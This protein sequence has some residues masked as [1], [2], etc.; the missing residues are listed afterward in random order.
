[1]TIHELTPRG[2]RQR[3]A[4]CATVVALVLAALLAARP[5]QAE[6]LRQR[7][8]S[9]T[10]IADTSFARSGGILL[11]RFLSSVRLGALHAVFEGRKAPAYWSRGAG[12][13]ALVPIPVTTPAGEGLLGIEVP[14]RRGLQRLRMVFPIGPRAFPSREQTVPE[15]KRALLAGGEALR[16]GR[17]LMQAVRTLTPKALWEGSFFEAPVVAPPAASFGARESYLGGEDVEDRMDGGFGDFHRG[18]DYP[19]APGTLVRAPAGGTVVMAAELRLSGRTLV[20][21]HGRGIVSAFYHLSRIDVPEGRVVEKR[22]LLGASGDS[23]IATFPHL[24]WG[25]YVHGIPVDPLAVVELSKL[26]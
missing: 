25:I 14:A 6:E 11:V 23:G 16:D 5:G 20:L 18:L 1:M 22:Q 24:H 3:S 8:G 7:F 15:S 12:L 21:D 17:R 4:R 10:V 9:V 2:H 19:L 26:L 13:H